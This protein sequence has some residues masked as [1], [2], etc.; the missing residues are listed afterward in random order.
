[1]S[2]QLQELE[3]E[4]TT[5]SKVTPDKWT[6][7]G[8]LTLM[9]NSMYTYTIEAEYRVLGRTLVQ[10][11]HVMCAH[12]GCLLT[13]SFLLR[14]LQPAQPSWSSRFSIRT[15]CNSASINY[16]RSEIA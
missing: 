7:V 13:K 12:R 16:K 6:V 8:F 4:S 14:E 11:M 9:S 2:L 1:M 15:I 10:V 5:I 3:M